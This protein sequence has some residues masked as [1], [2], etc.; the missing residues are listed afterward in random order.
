MSY[1]LV[2]ICRYVSDAQPGWV[3]CRLIDAAGAEHLFIEKVSVVTKAHLSGVTSYPRSG[4]LACTVIRT[5][6]RPDGSKVLQIDTQ[7]PWGVASTAGECRFEVLA[8][9]LV[10]S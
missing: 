6:A 9:Q 7:V 3:E 8:E 10:Q 4:L 1:L 5:R 2:E